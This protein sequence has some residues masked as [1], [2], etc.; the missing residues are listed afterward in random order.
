SRDSISSRRCNRVGRVAYITNA[1]LWRRSV[2]AAASYGS[3]QAIFG[4]KNVARKLLSPGVLGL[5]GP[6]GIAE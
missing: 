4:A 1:R 2:R 5:E 3:R 6:H